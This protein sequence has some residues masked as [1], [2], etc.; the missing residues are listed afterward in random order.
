MGTEQSEG[1]QN[2]Q[3]QQFSYLYVFNSF[4]ITFIILSEITSYEAF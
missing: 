2:L 3:H 1:I 4:N